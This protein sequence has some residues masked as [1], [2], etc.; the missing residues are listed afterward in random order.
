[1]TVA[2]FAAAGHSSSES[3]YTSGGEP[4]LNVIEKF[5]FAA[6]GNAIDVG[7]ISEVN[8]YAGSQSSTASGYRSAGFSPLYAY[9]NTIVKFPFASD[10]ITTDV[11]DLTAARMSPAGQQV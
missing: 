1:M 4:Y 11:G 5:P 6:D 10:G 3:G 8:I 7:D 2:Y 9:V